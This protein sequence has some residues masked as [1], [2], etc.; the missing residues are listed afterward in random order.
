MLSL[1]KKL[2]TSPS[3]LARS[4]WV[5]KKQEKVQNDQLKVTISSVERSSQKNVSKRI[6][7][8]VFKT[9]ATHSDALAPNK[10]RMLI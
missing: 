1:R 5:T 9:K 2:A 10:D 7:T 6:A 8:T 4:D 3:T